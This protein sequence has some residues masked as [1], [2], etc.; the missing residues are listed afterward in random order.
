MEDSSGPR[1]HDHADHHLP[2]T[3]GWFSDPQ[4][5]FISRAWAV[6]REKLDW[7]SSILNIWTPRAIVCGWHTSFPFFSCTH[8]PQRHPT[9]TPWCEEDGHTLLCFPF[10]EAWRS[11]PPLPHHHS[12]EEGSDSFFLFKQSQ[13]ITLPEFCSGP[14]GKR[15]PLLKAP[16]L[17]PWWLQMEMVAECSL[18]QGRAKP[19]VIQDELPEH[20]Q[21]IFWAQ[22]LQILV[23]SNKMEENV[24]SLPCIRPP[25]CHLALSTAPSISL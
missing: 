3:S 24:W 17:S 22:I 18:L 8:N 10:V 11:P 20:S 21:E 4:I 25:V 2:R 16:D 23:I 14:K 19:P 7:L 6:Y 13:D 12:Q 9:M 5:I 1:T 15:I